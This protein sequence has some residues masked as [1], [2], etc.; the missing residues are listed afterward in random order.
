MHF[1]LFFATTPCCHYL[2]SP[3]RRQCRVIAAA[4]DI[5]ADIIMPLII[6]SHTLCLSAYG[7]ARCY[8]RERERVCAKEYAL[9]RREPL[10]ADIDAQTDH[11]EQRDIA[12]AILL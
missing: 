3:P 1:S 12:D 7:A 8:L 5:F 10:R 11:A 6:S 4:D 2:F 9:R